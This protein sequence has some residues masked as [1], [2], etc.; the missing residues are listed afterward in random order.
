M[1]CKIKHVCLVKVFD[2]KWMLLFAE[3]SKAEINQLQQNN[4]QDTGK[5]WLNG[6]GQSEC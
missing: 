2:K 3:V 4:S 6:M 5:I 1:F